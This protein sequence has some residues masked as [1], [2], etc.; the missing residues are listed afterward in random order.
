M[1]SELW[2]PG[3]YGANNAPLAVL[4][5]PCSTISLSISPKHLSRGP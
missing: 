3:S 1:N 5:A 2:Q 4:R